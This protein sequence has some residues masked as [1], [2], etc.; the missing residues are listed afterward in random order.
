M[1]FAKGLTLAES[2]RYREALD[3]LE[4]ASALEP[5]NVSP[6][7]VQVYVYMR[8]IMPAPPEGFDRLGAVRRAEELLDE[9]LTIDPGNAEASQLKQAIVSVR[10]GREA[11]QGAGAP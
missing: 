3:A 6:R 2:D 10:R 7:L 1:L 11:Q 4:E 5:S 8:R 9:V